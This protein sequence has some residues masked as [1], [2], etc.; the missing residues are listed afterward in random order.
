MLLAAMCLPQ[1]MTMDL[2][3]SCQ[4]AFDSAYEVVKSVGPDDLVKPS[5][6]SEWD[7][8]GLTNHMVRTVSFFTGAARGSD[9]QFNP[10]AQED[11][12]GED[13]G[14]AYSSATA[15]F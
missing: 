14:A 4:R 3:D 5:P 6:C 11:V 12:V 13:P 2:L 10:N 7:V 8:R 1:E 9:A 15:D